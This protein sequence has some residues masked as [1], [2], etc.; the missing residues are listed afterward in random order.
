[1]LTW[2]VLWAAVLLGP[3]C[4]LVQVV[5][6]TGWE[7]SVASRF[8]YSNV[9]TSTAKCFEEETPLSCILPSSRLTPQHPQRACV[10]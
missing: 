8:L 3:P 10:L 7:V 9:P 2:Q 4:M 1:M 6:C 5:H